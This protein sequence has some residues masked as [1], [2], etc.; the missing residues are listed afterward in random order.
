MSKSTPILT[1]SE[2]QRNEIVALASSRT[3]EARIVERAR[4]EEGK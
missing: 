2:E 4:M 1:C 3:E